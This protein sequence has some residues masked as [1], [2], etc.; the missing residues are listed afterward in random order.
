MIAILQQASLVTSFYVY[1]KDRYLYIVWT[2]E[3]N[4]V[5]KNNQKK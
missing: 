3:H 2:K 4:D 5:F 1:D